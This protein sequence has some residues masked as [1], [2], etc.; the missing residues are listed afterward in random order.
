MYCL[1]KLLALV[2]ITPGS[3]HILW[4]FVLDHLWTEVIKSYKV[5]RVP[6]EYS[7]VIRLVWTLRGHSDHRFNYF[8]SSLMI[9]WS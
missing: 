3:L 9:H 4:T 6:A 8:L 5:T 2:N 1:K 7:R